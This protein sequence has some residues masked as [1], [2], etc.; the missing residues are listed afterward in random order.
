MYNF[1]LQNQHHLQL[2][3]IYEFKRKKSQVWTPSFL[4]FQYQL[5]WKTLSRSIALLVHLF[6]TFQKETYL[7]KT[8]TT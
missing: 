8:V 5:L 1:K 7:M 2:C 6:D 3:N 4:S